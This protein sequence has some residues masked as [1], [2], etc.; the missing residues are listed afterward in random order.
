MKERE[1]GNGSETEHFVPDRFVLVL[2]FVTLFNRYVLTVNHISVAYTYHCMK[3][4]CVR[5]GMGKL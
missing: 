5:L 1:R 4:F 3:V 2:H